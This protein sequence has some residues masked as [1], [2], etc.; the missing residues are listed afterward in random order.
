LLLGWND[1]EF[2]GAPKLHG[3]KQAVKQLTSLQMPVTKTSKA[4][5]EE[6]EMKGQEYNE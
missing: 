5:G 4:K 3:S 2:R 6:V 1:S